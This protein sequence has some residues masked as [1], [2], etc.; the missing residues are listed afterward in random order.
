MKK[1]KDMLARI[2]KALR[3]RSL[4]SKKQTDDLQVLEKF[5]CDYQ[6]QINSIRYTTLKFI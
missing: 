5:W 4:K 2:E 6:D 1:L 3:E